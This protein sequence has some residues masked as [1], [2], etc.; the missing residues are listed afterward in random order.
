MLRDINIPWLSTQLEGGLHQYASQVAKFAVNRK[1]ILYLLDGW[2]ASEFFVM[3]ICESDKGKLTMCHCG[4]K[5]GY[6]SYEVTSVAVKASVLGYSAQINILLIHFYVDT[7][8]MFCHHN[9]QYF[10]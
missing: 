10:K 9:L 4:K 6:I 5:M 8:L 1:K 7:S 3:L 2:N